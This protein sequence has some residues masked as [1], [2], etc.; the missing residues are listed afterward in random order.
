MTPDEDGNFT[1]EKYGNKSRA[2]AEKDTDRSY[3]LTM[4]NV[5]ESQM[6]KDLSKFIGDLKSV[7]TKH[8]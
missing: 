1:P 3:V 4:R 7:L 5:K 6:V 2:I 8:P